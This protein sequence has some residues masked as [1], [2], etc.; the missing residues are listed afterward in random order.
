MIVV[1]S[2]C[3]FYN[4]STFLLFRSLTITVETSVSHVRNTIYAVLF[5]CGICCWCCCEAA[6]SNAWKMPGK[7]VGQESGLPPHLCIRIRFSSINTETC[8]AVVPQRKIIGTCWRFRYTASYVK[9]RRV[10]S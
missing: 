4:V 1:L 5:I 6:S 10:L 2:D 8:E 7:T 3:D 9:I